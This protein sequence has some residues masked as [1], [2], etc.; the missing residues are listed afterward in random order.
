MANITHLPAHGS[1]FFSLRGRLLFLICLATLP[2]I[3]FTFFAAENERAATLT[4]MERDALHLAS[5]A[6]REHAHQIQGASE[7]L[8]W[9]GTKLAREGRQ[10]PILTDPDFQQAL[11]VG[12]PQLANIGVLSPDGQVLASAYP[13][14]S[15]RSWLDNP[16]YLAAMASDTVA[17]GSYIIS[18]IFDRP[19]LNHAYAVR[20][21]ERRVIAVL[22]NGLDLEWL[23]KMARQSYL[24]NGISLII[25]DREDRVLALG[26][27]E[28]P[29]LTD[30]GKMRIPGISELSRAQHGRM[31]EL[32]GA[33]IRRYFVAVPLDQAPGLYVS[34][35]LPY[36]QIMRQASSVFYR[37]L[38][39][40]G[41]LTLFT[42]A[43]V[44]IAAEL[45]I[46]RGLR[47]LAHAAQRLGSGDLS[48]RAILPRGYG[49]MSSLATAFN[50]MADSLAARHN[51]A[52]EAQAQL[53]A[54][55]HRLH[56]AREM[57]AAR[58]S[59]DLHDEIG[60]VLTSLKIDLS[61]LPACC[62]PGQQTQPCSAKLR[63]DVAAIN[64]QIGA[65]VDLV[66]RISSELR[67]VVLDKLGLTAALEWQAREIEAH[68]D[69]VVQVEAEN[70]NPALNEIVAV[71]L[72]R[73]AQ[74]ALT[75]V[76]RHAEASIIEIELKTADERVILTVSDNGVGIAAR[77]I[78]TIE[79]LGIIGMR[80]RAMLINGRLSIQGT[81][82]KG[83]TVTVT[84][85][86]QPIPK[87]ADA[88]TPG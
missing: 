70:A 6:S 51:E 16:A 69:L 27:T 22:F 61:R 54:L 75:N 80:E 45:G 30:I 64:R 47:A 11:L 18:P 78:D 40:L 71:T 66:R 65:A 26:G 1:W 84:A 82:G 48:T 57:E 85:P 44:F 12:H 87:A 73:I 56:I 81:P 36:E 32:A 63:D 79:S 52:I 28:D 41:I 20:D 39:G 83:T 23:S 55:A 68:T 38:S 31:L 13:L 62:P 2:A 3:L 25:T 72:F 34:A 19:T 29:E 33:G 15:Y 37:T 46:L 49:E 35:S 76:I 58:I 8:L 21:A 88:Y 60:Q 77:S 43:A 5:L 4:R 10:S 7:L 53:R 9:L 50:A 86:I 59:R 24:P 17:A 14:S 67:P 74:E 42:I